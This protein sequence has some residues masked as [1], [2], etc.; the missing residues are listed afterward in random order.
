[1]VLFQKSPVEPSLPPL[2][3][4]QVCLLFFQL[5]LQ[6]E[7]SFP[8][9]ASVA[10]AADA[11]AAAAAAEGGAGLFLSFRRRYTTDIPPQPCVPTTQ[12]LLCD[13]KMEVLLK[14]KKKHQRLRSN[15]V[16]TLRATWQQRQR[17]CRHFKKQRTVNLEENSPP[18][19][20]PSL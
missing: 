9:D 19:P 4:F 7:H 6:K 11:A 18:P 20:Q 10:A 2:L 15:R 16:C 12:H 13:F 1:M 8:T 5:S 14:T 17:G 3:L